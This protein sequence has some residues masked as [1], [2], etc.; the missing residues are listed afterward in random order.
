MKRTWIWFP[1]L[2]AFVL[3][4]GFAEEQN[5]TGAA[6]EA[7][8]PRLIRFSGILKNP[9]GQPRTG[10]VS[11]AFALYASQDASDSLWR[12]NQVI[13][14]DNEGRYTVLLG[15]SQ[16]DGLP[17][18]LF[19]TEQARWLGVQA[20]GEQEQARLLLVAVPYAMKAADAETVEGNSV[21]SFVLN[22]DWV[23]AKGDYNAYTNIL[24]QR[25]TMGSDGK[26]IT[27]SRALQNALPLQSG[28]GIYNANALEDTTNTFY[29]QNAG[30]ITTGFWNSFFGAGAGAYNTTG[31]INSFFGKDAGNANTTGYYNSF[32]GVDAG[33]ANTT[34]VYNSF[35]GVN[36]GQKNT[37]G[38]ANSF[39]GV[40]AGVGNTDGYQNSFFGFGA[41]SNNT[42]S[43]ANSFF[44]GYSGNA[45]TTGNLNSFVGNNSGKNNDTGAGNSF[46]GN[47]SGLSNTNGNANSFFGGSSGSNNTTG[48]DNSF[49]GYSAG[50]SNTTEY[51]NSFIGSF[52]DGA[53]GIANATAIGYQAKVTQSNS[54]VLGSINGVNGA[55][56]D[57]NVG[58][59]TTTPT[60]LLDVSKTASDG[61]IFNFHGPSGITGHVSQYSGYQYWTTDNGD[62]VLGSGTANSAS[63]MTNNVIRMTVNPA[64]NVGIGTT[65]PSAR[66]DVSKPDT[67][68]E[69]FN[70]H[71]PSGITGHVSQYAGY[72]YWTT[73][74]GNMVMGSGTANSASLMTNNAIRMTVD[75]T[76][77]VGIG[78][79]SPTS[80]LTVAGDIE[81]S[82]GFKIGGSTVVNMSGTYNVFVGPQAG[83]LNTTGSS[84]A[85]FGTGAGLSNTTGD[86]NSFFGAHSGAG[87]TTGNNNSFFGQGA[88]GWN[89]TGNFN[90]FFG[91][92]AGSGQMEAGVTGSSNSFFG[93]LAGH[94]ISAGMNNAFFG[95][96]SGQANSTG[97][98]NSFFGFSAG[99]SNTTASN[100]SF[101]GNA[102]GYSNTTSTNNSFF[103]DSSGYANT[104]GINNS[105]FGAGAGQ[106]NT[107]VC[108]NSFFGRSAGQ[109][110]TTGGG[111]SFFGFLSGQANTTG[112]QNAF[113]GNGSGQANTTAGS[114]SFFGFF[115]GQANTTG[116][117][118]SFFGNSAGLANTT[119]Y[120]NS[121]FGN[122]AGYANTT[123][124]YNSFFGRNAGMSNTT[125]VDNS[126]FGSYAGYM[127]TTGQA[128]SFFGNDAGN[129]N[130]V[131]NYNSFFGEGAG[132]LNTSGSSNSFFGEVSGRS[133]TTGYENAFFGRNAGYANTTGY[134]NS[135]FGYLAGYANTTGYS[136]AFFAEAAGASNTIGIA[137]SFFGQ[138][139]GRL[140][141]TGGYNSFLGSSAG[142]ANTT[143]NNNTAAGAGALQSNTSG[144]NNTAIGINA[145]SSN[146]TGTNNIG[147]G[148]DA[149]KDV[150]GSN[151]LSIANAGNAA[152]SNTIRIGIVTPTQNYPNA[153]SQTFIAGIAN[154][155][156][157]GSA[158]FIDSS[159]QL[160]IATSSRRFKD[161]IQDMR[162]ASSGLLR[163]RPV[164]FHYKP[165]YSKSAPG[166]QYGLIAEEVA[167]VYPEL[168][169]YDKDGKPFTVQYQVLSAML[170]NE[171]QKQQ[172]A[173]EK[174]DAEISTLKS[175]NLSLDARLTALERTMNRLAMQ[176]TENREGK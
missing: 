58:I 138:A 114:N 45:N 2:A 113:F 41:G 57:T 60:A 86:T 128:N 53:A 54:L 155:T 76:G 176:T 174:K 79:A 144:N 106:A 18:E 77:K 146:T 50:L 152:E 87:N 108:C 131:G 119:G 171:L 89:T 115:A 133:N 104:T 149:G 92:G 161:N 17:V 75:S 13:N 107:T 44:G 30:T 170:L 64:G 38:G 173:L 96:G 111:N 143:G 46:V 124:Y 80:K 47:N 52:S 136:N 59:G 21:S 109:A 82:T 26:L 101:F 168:V 1:I 126:F 56:A 73:D 5:S 163:L 117:S 71:G 3:A 167:E 175:Q 67:D 123:G 28:G 34:G 81:S 90:S 32:F 93:T 11:I 120:E 102:A 103:G 164:T 7:T 100:N 39:F 40:D 9:F 97:S 139:A 35:F 134:D 83:Q 48:A 142:Y 37:T 24:K 158:V 125:G 157:T 66:F 169:Q 140:N 112:S 118:N 85:F 69:I 20:D 55:T 6:V 62:M 127:T 72:Q 10:Q 84:N 95:N 49:F 29:G 162:E 110:N 116:G 151:N 15:S 19:S 154:A 135:F 145:L 172:T 91:D 14:T 31:F 63:L 78:T 8:A 160:G 156:V 65:T 16:K 137:N 36:A 61:E 42:T 159:G 88:G 74:N 105:F 4:A 12:E 68:G 148:L 147:I 98:Y 132:L 166:L 153:H 94:G 27:Q 150:T 130:T 99:G 33:Y 23:Q 70:F 129:A 25:G 22:V 43:Y 51:N 122:R 121:F 141:T 165:D